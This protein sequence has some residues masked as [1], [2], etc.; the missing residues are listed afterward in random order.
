MVYLTLLAEYLMGVA[1]QEVE[2]D[3]AR[4]LYC[5]ARGLLDTASRFSS[6][7]ISYRLLS[8]QLSLRLLK[9]NILCSESEKYC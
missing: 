6:A 9:E 5:R 8:Y 3:L 7:K 2:E 1:D 4:E